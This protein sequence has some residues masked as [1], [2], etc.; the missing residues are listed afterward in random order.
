MES[1]LSHE[2]LLEIIALQNEVAAGALELEAVMALV[3]RRAQEMTG[4]AGAV[5]ERAD[6]DDLVYHAGSGAGERHVG[7]RVHGG[8]GLSGRCLREE[9]ILYCPDARAG[10]RSPDRGGPVQG[11]VS[12]L[13]VPLV[14]RSRAVGVLKV[15]SNEARAFRPEHAATL[16]LLAQSVAAHLAHAEDL[17]HHS[18]ES[19]HDPLTG[20]PNRR[21]FEERLGSEVARVRRHGGQLSLCLADLDGFRVVNETLGHAV[22]DEVLRAVGRHLAE[23]RGEDAAF[24]LGGDEFGI[25]LVGA[26]LDGAATAAGRLE[27]AVLADHDCGGVAVS[28]GVAELEGG[29]PAVLLERAG[30]ALQSVKR[31]REP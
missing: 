12:I 9:K 28:C 25:I 6:G 1:Y 13:C 26:D 5:I 11:A 30:A 4:A 7:A 23:V 22:G 19:R 20:L 10:A 16:R 24:R 31:S 29:D 2:R 27:L 3:A 8:S 18:H 14:F 17:A 15:F 21:A